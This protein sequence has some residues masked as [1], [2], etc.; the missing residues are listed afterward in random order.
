MARMKVYIR[1]VDKDSGRAAWFNDT[2]YKEDY[3]TGKVKLNK[4]LTQQ[5]LMDGYCIY[6]KPAYFSDWRRGTPF[7]TIKSV[8]QAKKDADLLASWDGWEVKVELWKETTKGFI[9]VK[10]NRK[11]NRLEKLDPKKFVDPEDEDED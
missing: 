10:L 1:V 7:P 11:T 4:G 5:Y 6:G 8:M 2:T 9:P 3:D